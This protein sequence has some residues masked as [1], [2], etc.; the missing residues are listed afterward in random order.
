MSRH[1]KEVR[2]TKSKMDTHGHPTSLKAWMA[3]SV[4]SHIFLECIYKEGDG[5]YG[6]VDIK[7]SSMSEKIIV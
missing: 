2:P 7:E 6:S 1:A 4:C 5:G 3:K